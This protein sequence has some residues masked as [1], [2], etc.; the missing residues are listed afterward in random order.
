[1]ELGT[2]DWVSISAAFIALAALGVSTWEAV[3]A[4]RHSRLSVTPHLRVDTRAKPGKPI[5]VT[6]SNQ[7]IGPAIVRSFSLHDGRGWR[8]MDSPRE[9]HAVLGQLGWDSNQFE[10][11]FPMSGDGIAPGDEFALFD[12]PGTEGAEEDRRAVAGRLSD[13]RLRIEYECIYGRRVVQEPRLFVDGDEDST[14]RARGSG[15]TA[16]AG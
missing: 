14:G 6:L 15:G 13:L 9:V 4:R 1:M 3:M 8:S 7:G 10:Y 5:S 12:F 16:R 11:D 2:S